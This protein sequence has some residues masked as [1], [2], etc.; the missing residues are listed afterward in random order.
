MTPT[1]SHMQNSGSRSTG[2]AELGGGKS[3]VFSGKMGQ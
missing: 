3:F 2:V 1:E